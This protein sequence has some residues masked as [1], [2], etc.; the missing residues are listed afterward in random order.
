MQDT[1]IL[2]SV[3]STALFLLLINTFSITPNALGKIKK[4]EVSIIA[5]IVLGKSPWN[6]YVFI[7]ENENIHAVKI[8][9]KNIFFCAISW[10]FY[11]PKPCKQQL[12]KQELIQLLFNLQDSSYL[13]PRTTCQFVHFGNAN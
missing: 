10:S 12:K 1:A 9:E 6:K 7:S 4:Y 2:S 3:I 5:H 8:I 13:L 11:P